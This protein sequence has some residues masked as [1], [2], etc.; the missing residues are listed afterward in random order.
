M[1]RHWRLIGLVHPFPS[2]LNALLVLGLALLAGGGPAVAGGLALAML[3]LQF[4]IGAANDYFDVDLD[5]RSKPH[6]PI[7]A[8]LISRR[9][10][11]LLAVLCGA[12]ALVAASLYGP[13]ILLLAAAMLGAGLA[14]DAFLK[15]GPWAW[16]AYSFA[17]PMLPLYAWWGAS[18]QLPPQPELV[19]P[20]AALAGPALQLANG[21]VDVETDSRAG[22]ATLAGRLGQRRSLAVMAALL[23]V[24]H[25][26]AWLTLVLGG[27]ASVVSGLFVGGAS[28]LAGVGLLLSAAHQSQ[29]RERGWR[30]QALAIA[31]LVL[32]WLSAYVT[33]DVTGAL[34]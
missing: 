8:G 13:V 30:A 9:S 11:G 27:E 34:S 16:A 12:V 21:V 20:L 32:G 33:D 14:Y 28:L 15:R 31:L 26:L 2:A 3:A 22:I 19:L 5:A 7:T 4:C 6:K 18:G 17:F 24:I 29:T 1:A 10:A 23:A 25:G